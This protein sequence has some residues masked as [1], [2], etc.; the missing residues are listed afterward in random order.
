MIRLVTADGPD[1]VALQEVPVWALPR[2]ER[3]SG[4]AVTWA[5]TKR[6]LL[7]PLARVLQE[8]SPARVRSALTGQA[9]ALLVA[10]R[11][12]VTRSRDVLLARRGRAERRVAQV[13]DLKADGRPLVV[14]NL[15]LTT[16]RPERARAELDRVNALLGDAPAVVLGDTNLPG[17]GLEGFS[18]PLPGI[19]Q[20]LVR[21]LPLAQPARAWP[22]ERRRVEGRLLSDHPPI[23]AVIA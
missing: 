5:V 8:L 12:P 14:A 18:A 21:G 23:E 20:I 7:G 1:V 22:E 9:N 19:D 15:H 4:M 11:H 2:L 13:V 17:A 10:R 6:A 3:W 16:R